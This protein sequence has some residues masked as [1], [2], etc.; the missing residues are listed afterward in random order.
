MFDIPNNPS[1]TYLIYSLIF[2]GIFLFISGLN[3][4]KIEK[5]RVQTGLKTWIVGLV[6]II[7]GAF[8]L[9]TQDSQPDDQTMAYVCYKKQFSEDNLSYTYENCH[10]SAHPCTSGLS[11]FGIYHKGK[12]LNMALQRC[13]SNIPYHK[14]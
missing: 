7:V 10:E 6:L 2:L 3:I 1:I 13:I 4:I 9:N 8:L 12:E 5:I 11:K 14:D